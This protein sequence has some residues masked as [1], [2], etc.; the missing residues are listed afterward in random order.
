MHAPVA[1]ANLVSIMKGKEPELKYDGNS[2]CPIVTEYGK[3]LMCNLGYDKKLLSAIPFFDPAF[4]H[5]MWWVLKARGL[6]PMYYCGML[7]GLM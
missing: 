2:A 7:K 6:K 4:E 3:V 1:A 5:G